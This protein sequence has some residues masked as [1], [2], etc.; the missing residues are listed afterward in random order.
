VSELGIDPDGPVRFMQ[1]HI[2]LDYV[3][4][5]SP[6]SAH[7]A[8]QLREGRIVGQKC[9]SCGLVY[10]PQR[11]FCPMCVVGMGP[12][13]EV[14][15]ADRGT[16]TSFTLLT[17]IQYHGQQEREE[18]ALAS[19]LLDGA[20]GTVGQQRIVDVPLDQIRMG[21]RV[22]AVWAEPDKRGEGDRA[23]FGFG[24]AIT[25]WRPT[26]EPDTDREH[27]KDHVL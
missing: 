3:M 5:V 27:F 25:G 21:L 4:R 16:V 2:A 6:V 14:D 1:Q 22:E 24:E 15:V 10:V 12:A 26:G 9:P 18:Y 8:D 23:G 11:G 7:F 17:P 20:D 19:L 13:D